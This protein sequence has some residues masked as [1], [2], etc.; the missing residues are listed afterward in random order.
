MNKNIVL[1]LFSILISFLLPFI[2]V[3]VCQKVFTL[4]DA[5]FPQV[6]GQEL[7]EISGF[8]WV[9]IGWII[10]TIVGCSLDWKKEYEHNPNEANNPFDDDD[11]LDFSRDDLIFKSN[12]SSVKYSPYMIT[13]RENGFVH[14]RKGKFTKLEESFIVMG[15]D[16][17]ITAVLK[18]TK[19]EQLILLSS[20]QKMELD[21]R[22][23]AGFS[24][25]HAFN[26]ITQ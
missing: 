7:L 16:D 5:D 14:V 24:F 21:R 12:D 22:I 17:H 13:Y 15:E 23:L 10:P 11:C 1:L 8:Y 19:T 26:S 2:I 4:I 18:S 20:K 25:N 9:F 6:D 3:L